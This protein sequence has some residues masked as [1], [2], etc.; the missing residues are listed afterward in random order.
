MDLRQLEYFVR[1]SEYGGFT[2][3]AAALSSIGSTAGRQK[4]TGGPLV[5]RARSRVPSASTRRRKKWSR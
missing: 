2:K 3:A 1:V 5:S 4:L